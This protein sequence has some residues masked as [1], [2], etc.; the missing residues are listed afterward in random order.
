MI[1]MIVIAALTL[2]ILW[3]AYDNHT[4]RQS[5][6]KLIMSAQCIE[7]PD[8]KVVTTVANPG[9]GTLMCMYTDYTVKSVRR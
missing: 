8:R 9:E 6:A 4:L 5:T 1:R 3:L 2:T 7:Y